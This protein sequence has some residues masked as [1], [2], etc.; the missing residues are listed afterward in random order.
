MQYSATRDADLQNH[1]PTG[2]TDDIIFLVSSF[3]PI[4]GCRPR[5]DGFSHGSSAILDSELFSLKEPRLG[6]PCFIAGKI[7]L[8]AGV[9]RNIT[10]SDALGLGSY[11]T[12][13]RLGKLEPDRLI[14]PASRLLPDVFEALGRS[15][16]MFTHKWDSVDTYVKS[17]I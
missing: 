16:I 15:N 12:I 7:Q 4:S 8:D 9:V 6:H 2:Y 1:V 10:K 17:V 3:S 13:D 5:D 14:V 11:L